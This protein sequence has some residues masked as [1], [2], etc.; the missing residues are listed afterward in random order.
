M[1]S[2]LFPQALIPPRRITRCQS[3]RLLWHLTYCFVL[4]FLFFSFSFFFLMAASMAYAGSP[5]Q[6]LKLSHSCKLRHNW[7]NS[8]PTAPGQRSIPCLCSDPCCSQSLNSLCHN[9]LS[10]QAS[11]FQWSNESG[12]AKLL[13][14]EIHSAS[15]Q[16]AS[17]ALNWSMSIYALPWFIL[18][19]Y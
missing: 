19:P 16:R 6:G 5:G 9:G 2:L 11:V 8:D 18:C 17:K 13:P 14:W 7:C 3:S 12:I 1:K 4:F 15:E 10:Q